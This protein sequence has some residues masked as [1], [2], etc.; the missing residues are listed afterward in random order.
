[1]CSAMF[2]LELR[3]LPITMY[4]TH[5]WKPMSYSKQSV[6]SLTHI[7][8][9]KNLT[10]L[11]S[12]MRETSEL[13]LF[14]VSVENSILQQL[15]RSLGN[16]QVHLS[17]VDVSQPQPITLYLLCISSC[18]IS[19]WSQKVLICWSTWLFNNFLSQTLTNYMSARTKPFTL[20]VLCIRHAS[21]LF[22]ILS[23]TKRIEFVVEVERSK[24]LIALL[25]T[26][27]KSQ[28]NEFIEANKYLFHISHLLTNDIFWD[29]F[30][31]APC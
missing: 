10:V 19:Y 4:S 22:L 7:A 8:C 12:G 21:F 27:A 30:F 28:T 14:F 24:L 29:E 2:L 1:M 15:C 18:R 31:I 5:S 6:M 3:F 11:K 26:N 25:K 23:S 20:Y 16:I 17:E 13:V 9:L